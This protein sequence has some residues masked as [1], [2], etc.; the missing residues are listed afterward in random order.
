[1]ITIDN[2]TAL[3]SC[4]IFILGVFYMIR[5]EKILRIAEIERQLMDLPK[6]RV[7]YKTIKGKE[8]PYLQWS[9]NGG[10]SASRT[11]RWRRRRRR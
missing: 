1:M 7:F 9:E 10:S 4:G 2:L 5:Q 6:G 11:R 3:L 8:Q